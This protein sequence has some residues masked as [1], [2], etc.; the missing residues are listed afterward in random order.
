MSIFTWIGKAAKSL[1]TWLSKAF[2]DI[3]KDA[4]PAAVAIIEELKTLWG[5][6]IPGFLASILDTL[7]KSQLPSE[8][9]TAIG[10]ALPGL[11]ADALALEGLAT[12]P[13]T[14]QITAFE[15][16]VLAAFKVAPDQSQLYSTLGAQIIAIIRA[17]TAPGQKF[18]FAVLVSDLETAY[19]DYLQDQA[20]A[21]A[22]TA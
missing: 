9:V 4:A 11:L 17:N 7:L 5:G 14:A 10:N 13:T 22:T 6:A 16:A 18:T 3:T 19:Q 2:T 21:S 8:I 15:E 20:A 12:N 1:G